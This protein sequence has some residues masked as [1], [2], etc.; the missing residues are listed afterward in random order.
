MTDSVRALVRGPVADALWDLLER[1]HGVRLTT[2]PD[3]PVD[4]VVASAPVAT[5]DPTQFEDV[6]LIV[7][8]EDGR[9]AAAALDAGA[10]RC[11][12][13]SGDHEADAAHLAATV[14]HELETDAARSEYE[15]LL[16]E[17]LDALA[18]VFFLFDTEMRFLAW[19]ETLTEV[20]G[21]T[22]EEVASMEPLEFIA[23]EDTEPIMTA[24]ARALEEGRATETA[25]LETSDGQRIRYEFTGTALT[26]DDGELLGICGIGRDITE[27][28]HREQK[29][30]RQAERLRTLNRIN[31]VIRNVNRDL[32]RASTREEIER[33]VVER[34]GGEEPYRF[35]WLGEY[36]TTT[37]RVV[38]RVSAG[39][40]E[41]YLDAREELTFEDGDTTAET[42]LETREVQIAEYIADRPGVD[43]WREAALEAGYE[44][45]AAIPLVYR[46]VTY[47]VV[48]AYA[49]REDAF[50][51][52]ER[53]VLRELG[54]TIAYAISA[55]ER[56]RALLADT[57][58]ELEFRLNDRSQFPV[59]AS[60]AGATVE[61]TG[62]VPG[63]DGG[64]I[65]FYRVEGT[66]PSTVLEETEVD[67]T[68]V[69]ESGDAG[70]VRVSADEGL[71]EVL[72]DFGGAIRSV[73]ADDGE[74]RV[75][76]TFPPGTD[77]RRVVEVVQDF[78]TGAELV[79]RR[80]RER[81]DAGRNGHDATQ[82]LTDRQ[83][84]VLTT[85]YLSGF[86]D[87]PRANTGADIAEMLDISTPTFH[88]H[89][90]IAERKLVEAFLDPRPDAE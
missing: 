8:H 87:A 44:S 17:S 21:Y 47:G 13:L 89:I 34:L 14:R 68:V 43:A 28:H 26:D 72:A 46:D 56:R 41:A 55:A 30:E 19:N 67:G 24:I 36:D 38:P 78:S 27:R 52:T 37:G 61:F 6:P 22:D 70:V 40:G 11:V 74:A 80:E 76:A 33:A 7:L 73:E 2:E 4:C 48:C 42:A 64:L 86:F 79:A 58:V 16:Q 81:A 53:D 54:E 83:R 85:A 50:D 62:A 10:D 77:V 60:L 23:D 39:A 5:G 18:D 75:R 35:A 15:S 9:A 57:V 82:A 20:T 88:E 51:Q 84:T 45:A 63:D 3:D 71:G 90:R 69:R 12:H 25:F 32:V 59:A 66:A 1:E 29:L 49:P 31:E 65:R